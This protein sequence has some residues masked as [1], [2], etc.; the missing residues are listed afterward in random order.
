MDRWL[1]AD[2]A[3]SNVAHGRVHPALYD[4]LRRADRNYGPTLAM[5][6]RRMRRPRRAYY[7]AYLAAVEQF[8]KMYSAL[9]YDSHSTGEVVMPLKLLAGNR[10]INEAVIKNGSQ[11]LATEICLAAEPG[12][13]PAVKSVHPSG[14]GALDRL[15]REALVKAFPVGPLPADLPRC[16]A[17]YRFGVAFGRTLPAPYSGCTFTGLLHNFKCTDQGSEFFFKKVRLVKVYL[18]PSIVGATGR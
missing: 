4:L 10:L 17:C 9:P 14:V 2:Q 18:P 11:Q 5:V 1:G 15:A 13:A 12:R 7:R 6:P 3:A 16:T 8:N